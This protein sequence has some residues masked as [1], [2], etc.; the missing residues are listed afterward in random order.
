MQDVEDEVREI[1]REIVESRGLIIKTNN[2]VNSLGA[3]IKAIAKRQ[4]GYERRFK[5]DSGIAILVIGVVTFA[6]LKLWYDAQMSSYR[7]DMKLAETAA[8]ELRTDLG[9]EVQRTAERAGASA[10]A[11][12]YYELIRAR[13]RGE[14]VRQYASVS[15]EALTPVEAAVF[16]DYERQFR[17]ELALE[18]YKKGLALAESRKY[19]EA[20]KRYEQALELDPDGPRAPAVQAALA[21]SLRKNG[22]AAEALVLARQVASQEADSALQ[23]DGW[24]IVA[25]SARDVGDLDTSREAAR[26]LINKW[27]RSALARDARPLLRDVTKQIYLGKQAGGEAAAAAEPAASQN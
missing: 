7:N 18:L 16:R 23:P 3:D 8:E 9:D 11:E 2:L 26:I 12:A 19:S 27:P 10:K 1:K 21:Y 5:I 6:G 25:L 24:W 4:A 20:I 15:K 13:D 17:S 14:V 22:R